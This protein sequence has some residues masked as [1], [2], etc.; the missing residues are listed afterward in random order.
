MKKIIGSALNHPVSTVM[1]FISLLLLGG[2]SIR[3]MPIRLLPDISYPKILILTQYRGLPPDAIREDIT[4][5]LE[6]GFSSLKGLKNIQSI[7]RNGLSAIT[8]EFHWGTQQQEALTYTKEAVDRIYP[9]LPNQAEKPMVYPYSPEDTPLC[10]IGVFPKDNCDLVL[11]RNLAER[12][13]KTRL[14]QI[15]GVGS[16]SLRG[17][18]TQEVTV[19]LDQGQASVLGLTPQSVAQHIEN[20]NQEIPAGT[21]LMGNMEYSITTQSRF[22]NLLELKELAIPLANQQTVELDIFSDIQLSHAD[23]NSLFMFNDREGIA[24][25]IRS[26]SNSN[27]LKTAMHIREELTWLQ[28]YFHRDVQLQLLQDNSSLIG[29]TLL[30]LVVSGLMGALAAFFIL[31]IFLRHVN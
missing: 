18:I 5:P 13:I 1:F 14:Q 10:V 31:W 23:Q 28:S 26:A 4:I 8:L 24:L 22:E 30:D 17:G 19:D 6:D 3:R 2:L 12:D 21:L 16:V 7:S 15:P 29:N 20:Y 9:Q 25:I 27:P 11:A